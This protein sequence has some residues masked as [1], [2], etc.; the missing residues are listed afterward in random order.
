LLSGLSVGAREIA[1]AASRRETLVMGV[2][3]VTPDS[4]YPASAASEP[5]DALG[6]A[7]MLHTQGADIL[8]VGGE[9]S[10]PGSDSVGLEE[11]LRRILP[12][13][14]ALSGISATLSVDTYRAETA[15]RAIGFGAT[16]VNDITALRGDPEMAAVVAESNA[17]CVLMHMLGDPKTMQVAPKYEDVVDDIIRFFEERMEYA[18]SEGIA[19]DRIWLDPGFGFGKTVDHNLTILRRLREFKSLGRPIVV[20]TSNKSTIGSVLD[21]PVDERVEGTAAT[22]AIAIWNGAD[23][24][25]VHDVAQMKRVAAMT[26]AIVWKGAG[27][28]KVDGERSG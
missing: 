6:H 12:V 27:Q 1:A 10:R 22:V 23:C 4:F 26:D 25:R 8:D 15:R 5:E 11:E 21:L 2:V 13:F 17:D 3:N 14:E 9:S 18:I 19:E 7:C 20:G 28:K 24:V 16:L